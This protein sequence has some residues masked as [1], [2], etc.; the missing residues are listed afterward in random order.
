MPPAPYHGGH[1]LADIIHDLYQQLHSLRKV[2]D[3]LVEYLADGETSPPLSP[4]WFLEWASTYE[5]GDGWMRFG[6]RRI[7]IVVD[8]KRRDSAEF[9]FHPRPSQFGEP[10]PATPSEPAV[11]EEPSQPDADP[12]SA[13]IEEDPPANAAA[14]LPSGHWHLLGVVLEEW[15]RG[16]LS[17][18]LIQE[19]FARLVENGAIKLSEALPERWLMSLV[20]SG[21]RVTGKQHFLFIAPGGKEFWADD[22][23][24]QLSDLRILNPRLLH[25]F[26]VPAVVE[27]PDDASLSPEEQPEATPET[28]GRE[29]AVW[30]ETLIPLLN[31]LRDGHQL[32]NKSAAYHAVNNCLTGRGQPMTKSSIYEG[33]NRHQAEWRPPP[34]KK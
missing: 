29:L 4:G 1:S 20:R 2:Q 9:R 17:V 11:E 16:G 13:T 28:D 21:S 32:R 12:P 3:A 27:T 33:L 19:Y 24:C 30:R 8:G 7:M 18:P 25:L 6:G 26:L 15:R 34:A 14:S 23:G 5:E 22:L 31:T 10:R